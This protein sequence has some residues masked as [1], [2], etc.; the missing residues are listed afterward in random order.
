MGELTQRQRELMGQAKQRLEGN[1]NVPTQRLRALGQGISFNTTDELEAFAR[2]LVTGRPYDEIVQEIN[3]KL[4]AYSEARPMEAMSY[5]I[6]G[7]VLPAIAAAPF[8]GGTSLTTLATRAPTLMKLL[9]M[10]APKSFKEALKWGAIHGGLSGFGSGEDLESRL[11]GGAVGTV[12]GGIMGGATEKIVPLIG[13]VAMDVI[14]YARR[15]IGNRGSRMVENELQRLASESGM[16]ID[17]IVDGVANGTIMAENRTLQDAVRGYRASGGEG[18][19]KLKETFTERPIATRQEAM[20]NVEGGLSD[21]VDPNIERAMRANADQARVLER[22]SYAPFKDQIASPE[23][24]EDVKEAILRVPQVKGALNKIHRSQTGS[25]EPLVKIVDGEITFASD[26]SVEMA[27]EARRLVNDVVKN[28]YNRGLGTVAASWG[29]VERTLRNALDINVPDLADTRNIAKMTREARDAYIDGQNA[30]TKSSDILELEIE[31]ARSQGGDALKAYRIGAF[32]QIRKTMGTSRFKS[33][34]ASLTDP[35]KR[36]SKALALLLPDGNA[37]KVIKSL[38]RANLSQEASSR[39]LQGSD[40]AITQGQKARQGSSVGASDI[41]E[42]LGGNPMAAMRFVSKLLK[43]SAPELTDTER[44][45]IVEVLV[46]ENPDIVRNALR[47]ESGMAKLQSFLGNLGYTA[48]AGV[49]RGATV[50]VSPMIGDKAVGLLGN[51]N[52]Q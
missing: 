50:G 33:F 3:D 45:Q 38:E 17:E 10:V 15:K 25:T 37:D 36:E 18:A 39:V 30:F 42:T 20:S 7:A 27:E 34:M 21:V 5:E 9:G 43:K 14:D 35:Q 29:D 8:S 52:T 4:S 16:T 11:T 6:G 49:Q 47:D 23:I 41:V 22:E 13:G 26:I 24:M 12:A 2:S 32:Q 31:K 19:T 51:S 44:L 46:S 40:T 28:E 1:Q 48:K